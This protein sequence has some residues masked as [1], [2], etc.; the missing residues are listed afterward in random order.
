[1]K[2]YGKRYE[3]EEIVSGG[4]LEQEG[5]GEARGGTLEAARRLGQVEIQ[6]KKGKG[7]D[8]SGK[9]GFGVILSVGE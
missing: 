9:G 6:C 1:M 2:S 4:L 8:R 5:K 7:R 3:K